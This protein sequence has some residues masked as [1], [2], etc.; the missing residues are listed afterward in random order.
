MPVISVTE[1]NIVHTPTVSEG[2][3][4]STIGNN[5]TPEPIR[6][7]VANVAQIKSHL[8]IFSTANL[9]LFY[10]ITIYFY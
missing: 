2:S 5:K 6:N 7:N 10:C 8:P 4:L 3:I 9:Q 1:V